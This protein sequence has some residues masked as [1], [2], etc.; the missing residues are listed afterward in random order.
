[1]MYIIEYN[2][3]DDFLKIIIHLIDIDKNIIKYI[4]IKYL[5][6][7]NFREI[8]YYI[9]LQLFFYNFVCLYYCQ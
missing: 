3:Y 1:M 5:R 2:E 4:F 6:N 8:V 7:V 9:I